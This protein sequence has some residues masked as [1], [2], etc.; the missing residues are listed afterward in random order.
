MNIAVIL[1][2]VRS[3]ENVGSI[4]RTS[5]AA[6]VSKIYLTGYTPTP[7][8]RFKRKNTKLSKAALGAEDTVLWESTSGIRELIQRLQKEGMQVVAV[9]QSPAAIPYTGWRPEKPVAFV[10]GNEVEG[11]PQEVLSICDAI[12]EIP[13]HGKKESLNVAVSAGII[14]FHAKTY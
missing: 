2:D 7:L 3:S 4:F 9:E 13:M 10:F 6:G 11:V 12:V 5:D 14:L 8:D 1:H